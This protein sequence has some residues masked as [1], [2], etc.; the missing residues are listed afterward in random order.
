[1]FITK[2]PA[3]EEQTIITNILDKGHGDGQSARII[4]ERI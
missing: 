4:V 1:M 3:Q 2:T